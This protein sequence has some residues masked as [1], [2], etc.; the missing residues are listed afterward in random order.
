MS[1]K[2]AMLREAGI[3]RLVLQITV[4]DSIKE[5]VASFY[6][7]ILDA[8]SEMPDSTDTNYV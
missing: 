3:E 8:H 5:D 7:A 4:A 1:I 2:I 6:L